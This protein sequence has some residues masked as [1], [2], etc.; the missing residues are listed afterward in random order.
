LSQARTM[1]FLVEFQS[2][3]QASRRFWTVQ[4]MYR[5]GYPELTSLWALT[6]GIGPNA[7]LSIPNAL[8]LSGDKPAGIDPNRFKL[9]RL[10]FDEDD[11]VL[12]VDTQ[13]AQYRQADD[14]WGETYRSPSLG[15]HVLPFDP[16]M[17]AKD[18]VVDWR[19]DVLSPGPGRDVLRVI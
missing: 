16:S 4:W 19:H 11:L 9:M 1:A 5:T 6:A 12:H 14:N 2:D 8:V 7:H 13:I 18:S 3:D 17:F 10:N 15:D